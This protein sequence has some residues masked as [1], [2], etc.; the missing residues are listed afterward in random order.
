MYIYTYTYTYMYTFLY[1]NVGVIT[2][3]FKTFK[4]HCSSTF[5]NLLRTFLFF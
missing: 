4:T 5:T 3:N 1:A 2:Y